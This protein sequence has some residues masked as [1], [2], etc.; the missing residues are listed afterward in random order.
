MI[1]QMLVLQLL[2]LYF[3][4]WWFCVALHVEHPYPQ[5]FQLRI[6]IKGLLVCTLAVGGWVWLFWSFSLFVCIE[7]WRLGLSFGSLSWRCVWLVVGWYVSV[8]AVRR[9]SAKLLNAVEGDVLLEC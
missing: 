9:L 4:C 1:V 2:Y 3:R 6:R 5:Y 7:I 8:D